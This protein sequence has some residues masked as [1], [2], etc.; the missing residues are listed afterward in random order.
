MTA[1]PSCPPTSTTTRS[2][3]T[4]V[5][6]F[7]A[8][9]EEL[10]G[11]AGTYRLRIG[12]NEA[13]PLPTVVV[14]PTTDG[15]NAEAGQVVDTAN[16]ALGTLTDQSKTISGFIGGFIDPDGVVITPAGGE[17]DPGHRIAFGQDQHVRGPVDAD[18]INT[19]V[20]NFSSTYRN[21]VEDGDPPALTNQITEA[22]KNLARQVFDVYSYYL[23][24]EFEESDTEGIIIATGNED[25]EDAI[26]VIG[27]NFDE[28]YG[29]DWFQQAM[30]QI[31]FGIGLGIAEDLPEGTIMGGPDGAFGGDVEDTFRADQRLT[32][33]ARSGGSFPRRSRRGSRAVPVLPVGRRCGHVPVYVDGTGS[34]QP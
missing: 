19:L 7:S 29:G 6:T 14:D 9:I 3:D 1:S 26:V 24:I 22:Q 12:T 20:Y 30:F 16:S 23:G 28:S 32:F 5:L 21:P 13:V 11:G 4:A 17:N 34:R 25:S 2:T 8:N 15:N 31:G 18:G 27:S 33:R 10:A